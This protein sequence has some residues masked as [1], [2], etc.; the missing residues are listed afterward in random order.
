MNVI[1]EIHSDR[2]EFSS[3]DRRVTVP[4]A[5]WPLPDQ[6]WMTEFRMASDLMRTGL[7]RLGALTSG[8]LRPNLALVIADIT[9]G[10]SPVAK[11]A[12][13]SAAFIGGAGSVA[14]KVGA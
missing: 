1:V 12:I 6:P 4:F 14:W 10:I 3:G 13:E 5:D 11:K 8:K 9:Q 7:T 2:L